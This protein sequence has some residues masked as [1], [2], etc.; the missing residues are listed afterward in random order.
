MA[1][2]DDSANEVVGELMRGLEDEAAGCRAAAAALSG[3][4]FKSS[5]ADLEEHTHIII[6]AHCVFVR[7]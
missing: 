7:C 2:D 4:Y 6:G 5:Q 1:V 3:F